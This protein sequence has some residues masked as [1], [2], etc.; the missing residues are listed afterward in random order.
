MKNKVR[1]GFGFDLRNPVPWRKSWVD[2]YRE[3]LEF[4][5]WTEVLGFEQVW[6]AEHHGDEDGY[7][8]SPL[9]VC[10]TLAGMTRTMRL[11]TGIGLAPFYH[12][13]RLAE[14]VA[15]LDLISNGRIELALGLGY[16]HREFKAYGVDVRTR[17]R[18]T[19]EILQI[20]RRL[21]R[22]EEVTFKGEFYQLE[23]AKIFPLPIQQPHIPIY[24]GGAVKA[25]Y[26]RAAKYGD[27]YFGPT[28]SI[29]DYMTAVRELGKQD[30]DGRVALIGT[31]DSWLVVADDPERAM[32][33]VAPHYFYQYN[34]Y[35]RWLEEGDFVLPKMDLEQFKQSGIL[36][37]LTPEQA[38]EHIKTRLQTHPQL[39]SYALQ[40]PVGLSM[41]KFAPYVEAFAQRV[42]PA[43]KVN[44]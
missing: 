29:A 12:P 4:V 11:S 41:D 40:A 44:D 43:F 39:D 1:F 5:A 10:A 38:I 42:L 23:K 26:R 16:L 33:E 18:R 7:C 9:V 27:G 32:A 19:D 36:N 30:S 13:T 37:A 3:H 25:G 17:G 14:D 34:V 21:W 2:H 8:P 28:E 20:L 6:I 15:V 31:A 24:V 22:G 35:A